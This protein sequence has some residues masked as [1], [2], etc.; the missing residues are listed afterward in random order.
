MQQRAFRTWCPLF[1]GAGVAEQVGTHLKSLKASKPLLIYDKGIEST[2]HHKRVLDTLAKEGISCVTN[3][4]VIPDPPDHLVHSIRD[5]AKKNGVDSLIALGGGSTIDTAKAVNVLLG[6]PGDIEDYF[7][8]TRPRKL[9]CPLIAIPTTFGTS[10]E[11]SGAA[12]ITHSASGTKRAVLFTPATMAFIDPQFGV[13]TPRHI[14]FS[15]AFDVLAHAID[16]FLSNKSNALTKIISRDSATLCKEGIPMIGADNR[17]LAAWDK[18]A[19]ASALGGMSIG[20]SGTSFAHSFGHSLGAVYKKAHGI[21]VGLFIPASIELVAGAA[22]DEV[23]TIASIF[24]VAFSPSDPIEEIARK[25]GETIYR[26]YLTTGLPALAEI[27]PNEESCDQIIPKVLTDFS[28]DN[29]MIPLT[30]EMARWA[31]RRT[32][33]LHTALANA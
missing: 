32:Y 5:F 1:Y 18:M 4:E 9:G 13:G 23:R 6:S 29:G 3:N 11:G 10:S 7:D 25:T 28:A 12:M 14:A 22:P 8:P 24:E 15:C 30:E 27:E 33:E 19:M 21:C 16:G 20:G 17:D 26:L 2:G 31:I